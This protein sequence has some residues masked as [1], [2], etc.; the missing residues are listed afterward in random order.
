MTP[1][2]LS[3]L[4][5]P[6]VA[7]LALAASAVAEP[8]ATPGDTRLRSDLELVANAGLLD[9]ITT[10]W[11][12]PWDGVLGRL[13]DPAAYAAQPRYIR[14][15]ATRLV[16]Q[17]LA[18]SATDHVRLGATLDGT[19]Q[20][21]SV[22][23][24]DAQ[25]RGRVT[26]QGIADWN[27]ENI[28][29][30][31]AAGV[32]IDAQE[33]AGHIDRNKLRIAPDGSYVAQRIGGTLLYA[34]YV[35][36]WWGPGWS[37]ALTLSTNA[38]PFPQVGLTRMSSSP[39]ASR[40]LRWLG[41]WRFEVGAGLLDDQRLAT[42][43]LWDGI[44]FTFNPAKG[45]EI[46]GARTQIFCGRGH[47]C[48]VYKAVFN[49]SNN[50]AHPSISSS[51]GE[52]DVRWTSHLWHHP[53]SVY[54]QIMNEDS[55][56]IRHSLSSHLI[57]AT[58][59]LPV[60]NN[61]ARITAEYVSSISTFD[62][63]SFNTIGYGVSYTDYKYPIDGTRYRGRALGYSL[64]S[65]SR[66]IMLQGSV[67]DAANRNW[68]LT[69]Y[70]AYVSTPFTNTGAALSDNPLTTTPVTIDIGEAKVAMPLSWGDLTFT[71][72]VQDDQFRPKHGFSAGGEISAI[73][74]FR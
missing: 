67:V 12:I 38:R 10:Q 69:G 3:I 42:H 2:R 29:V 70:R 28:Y 51:Q 14:E 24:F 7:A 52:F 32:L 17:A 30:H 8:W 57:G 39:F 50:D 21:N 40:F 31:V 68:T 11:P 65:D 53:F 41:P 19:N 26:T 55:S 63:F 9:N 54:T 45:L 5:A 66:L 1:F 33:A 44:R 71:G 47:P 59:W 48:N 23:G 37:T 35:P 36:H 15:A 43:S 74:R 18:A 16:A 13:Q 72:R 25:G 27:S 58:T 4:A 62:I 22:R 56:P 73:V 34:G 64:D 6:L 61:T 46:G 20:P 49:L 60:G